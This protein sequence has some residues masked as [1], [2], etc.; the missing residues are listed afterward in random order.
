MAEPRIPGSSTADQYDGVEEAEHV[1]QRGEGRML[2]V[3]VQND[4]GHLEVGAAQVELQ[5]VRRLRHH[6]TNGNTSTC[7][8]E[9]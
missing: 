9:Q 8:G 1:D 5:T 4:A 7:M 3:G 2:R 6:Y